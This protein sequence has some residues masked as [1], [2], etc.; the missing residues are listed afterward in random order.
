MKFSARLFTIKISQ[1]TTVRGCSGPRPKQA[2]REPLTRCPE[3]RRRL[4]RVAASGLLGIPCLP[5]CEFPARVAGGESQQNTR[6]GALSSRSGLVRMGDVF[7][8]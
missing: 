4:V 1:P 3:L 6:F 8:A 2:G 7:V 5:N